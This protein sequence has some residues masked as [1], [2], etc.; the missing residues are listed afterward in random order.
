MVK[1]ID[2]WQAC[3]KLEPR[4]VE[5]PSCKGDICTLNMS[6]LKRPPVGVVW[7]I[8]SE[9][10]VVKSWALVQ[11]S[12]PSRRR[13]ICGLESMAIGVWNPEKDKEL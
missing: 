8:K 13:L 7:K 1:I 10:M 9:L 5:D 12:P 6:K 11:M 2:S 3:H 4:T